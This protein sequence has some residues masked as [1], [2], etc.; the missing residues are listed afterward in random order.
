MDKVFKY[1]AFFSQND[2][3]GQ[4][5]S[6]VIQIHHSK[7]THGSFLS[8]NGQKSLFFSFSPGTW[9]NP[10]EHGFLFHKMIV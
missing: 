4:D 7:L 9:E 1:I 5:T 2:S 8:L 3:L 10:M 6:F